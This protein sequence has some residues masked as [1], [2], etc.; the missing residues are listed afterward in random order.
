MKESGAHPTQ[1]RAAFVLLFEQLIAAKR[2]EQQLGHRL[3]FELVL[4][5]LPRVC[6]RRHPPIIALVVNTFETV[7]LVRNEKFELSAYRN[8]GAV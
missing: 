2:A 7:G 4:L 8:G 1:G 6:D 3:V 5:G